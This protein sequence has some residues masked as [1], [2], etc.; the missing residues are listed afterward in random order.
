MT[1]SPQREFVARMS[2]LGAALAFV[3]AFCAARGIGS[4]DT[5]R[6]TLIVEELFT[7]TVEHG[8]GG[9]SDC[10]VALA[11]DGDD[12]H[13]R[14][15]YEDAAAPFDPR[16][17]LAGAADG[18]GDTAQEHRVGGVGLHLVARLAARIDY[19]RE[20]GRNRL[21]LVLIRRSAP[22]LRPARR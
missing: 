17:H 3:E 15:D 22:D 13:V 2:D 20:D 9:D 6:L 10:A 16:P 18:A 11:L 4:D 14:L 1:D 12:E 8:C 21:R 7:N 5:L 19:T